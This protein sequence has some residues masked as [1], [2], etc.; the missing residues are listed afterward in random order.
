MGLSHVCLAIRDMPD[1]QLSMRSGGLY[2]V[3]VDRVGDTETLALQGL[4]A[5][6]AQHRATLVWSGY[7]PE[8]LISALN[9]RSATGPS[10]LFEVAETD[11]H[12]ALQ[13]LPSELRRAATT[14]GSLL[15]LMLPATSW[16]A[17][18]AASLQRWCEG[19]RRWLREHRCTLLVL[20]HGQAPRL[21]GELVRLDEYL[22][23]LA[24][25][26]RRDGGI[27]YQS[28]FWHNDH[29][30]CGAREFEFELHATG[31]GLSQA[32]Q[33]SP[34]P[35]RTDDQRIY[36]AQRTVLEGAAVPSQQ[37]SVFERRID[38]LQQATQARA[39]SV[40]VAV[41]SD[42]QVEALARDLYA[43][44]QRC[45]TALKIIVRE[46]EPCL[47]Y[48]DERLLMTCGA[49][50]IVPFGNALPRF[51]SLVDSVQG[52]VWRRRRASRDL[53]SLLARLRAPMTRGLLAPREFLSA[54]EQIYGGAS[55]EV[56]HQLLRL[57]P[58][59]ALTIEQC[60]HQI[61]LRR[62]GDIATVVDGVFYLFLF[63]C[64]SDG[65]ESALG[66]IC[67]LPWRTLF[68]DCQP[69]AEL[70]ALPRTAFHDAASLPDTLCLARDGTET[71]TRARAEMGAYLPERARLAIM[72]CCE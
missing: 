41:E 15:L 28:H 16:Q 40:M 7:V 18:D 29:G 47:R 33:A 62:F 37:W 12:L 36:L 52:Q 49:N 50:I 72:D 9:E 1:E 69:L 30:V 35:T 8:Q 32:E 54:L 11:I 68:S 39:A 3:C 38:L 51:F 48:R 61:N 14:S 25:L 46:M 20:C 59:P 57:Q 5:L 53:E 31:F 22:S 65:L 21:H 55:G 43:L 26:Y 17:F 27:H 70:D 34:T 63:A 66:N 4:R 19:M 13:S 56:E 67:R 71:V 42:Q 44:R 2:W 23:G 10:H 6:P 60:L 58:R 64:R 45:G 24:Q